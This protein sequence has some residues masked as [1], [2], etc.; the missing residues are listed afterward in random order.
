MP[1]KQA[2]VNHH[3]LIET[4]AFD[5]LGLDF[6]LLLLL[7]NASQEGVVNNLSKVCKWILGLLR[8]EVM[9]I[10][11]AIFRKQSPR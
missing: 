2:I 4:S 7:L 3:N 8:V 1:R 9:D 6:Q 11:D 5:N 10:L